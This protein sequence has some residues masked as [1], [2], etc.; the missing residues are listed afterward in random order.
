MNR[1]VRPPAIWASLG[2]DFLRLPWS[3]A[4]SEVGPTKSD[5]GSRHDDAAPARVC[6]FA[7]LLFAPY[8]RIP[9]PLAR[10][11]LV[12]ARSV[13]TQRSRAITRNCPDCF[14]RLAMTKRD[15]GTKKG[16]GKE[17]RETK[18]RSADRAGKTERAAWDGKRKKAKTPPRSRPRRPLNP[19]LCFADRTGPR[20]PAFP[21]RR[22]PSGP[23]P[24]R[25]EGAL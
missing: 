7:P 9:C 1:F 10:L 12:I 6:F 2:A 11:P 5:P 14:A 21:R 3:G 23:G 22:E 17:P 13:A 25:T 19:N 16:D 8:L 24:F 15:E 20:S 4:A 18:V